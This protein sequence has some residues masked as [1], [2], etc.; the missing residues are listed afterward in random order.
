MMAF[1]SGPRDS[2]RNDL[3]WL[4]LCLGR[5]CSGSFAT[6]LSLDWLLHLLK[7]PGSLGTHLLYSSVLSCGSRRAS[8][9]TSEGLASGDH[10]TWCPFLGLA[11]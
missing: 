5:P 2:G 9:G 4:I 1:K 7:D 6:M 11:F 3:W 10:R 8:S